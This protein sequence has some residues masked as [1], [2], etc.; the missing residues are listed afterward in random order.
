[1]TR[2]G[3]Q[4]TERASLAAKSPEAIALIAESS[5]IVADVLVLLAEHVVPGVTTRRLDEIAEE[6]IRSCGA[7]PAFKGY[8]V[9]GLVFPATLCTSVNDAVVHGIPDE[10]ELREGDIVSLDVGALRSGYYGDGAHTYPV[11]EVD[12]E[13]QRLMRVTREALALGIAQ[14]VAG[15]RVFDISRAVQQ[16]VESCG[17]SVVRELVGHGIGTTLHEEPAVPNFVPGPF[18]RHQFRNALLTDGT[19]ICIEPMVNAGSHRVATDPD[20]WTIRTT[21][22]RPSAHYEHTVVVRAAGAEILTTPTD[23]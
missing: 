7:E 2:T 20:G 6:Y 17:Y 4:H 1:M 14:A 10:R 11:G 18:Q 8:R 15:N 19:V 13:K 9:H 23:G 21:D 16:H 5:R 12:E 22:G 3:T